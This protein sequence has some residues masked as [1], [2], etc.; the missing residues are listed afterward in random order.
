MPKG[1]TVCEIPDEPDTVAFLDGPV[2]LAGLCDQETT[3]R[4]DKTQP[5]TIL[6]PDNEWQRRWRTWLSY[7]TVGQP[8]NIRFRPLHEIVDE[9]YTV[10]F[11]LRAR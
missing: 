9:R 3:L 6:K 1:L 10:Y 4:G 7:R 5:G 8:V 2:V 11:P